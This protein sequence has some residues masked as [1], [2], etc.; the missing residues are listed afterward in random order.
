MMRRRR[1]FGAVYKTK[2]VKSL[3]APIGIY[4]GEADARFSVITSARY[5]WGYIAFTILMGHGQD[6]IGV[7]G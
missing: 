7:G 4:S 1:Y 6:D 5:G 2:T 3:D